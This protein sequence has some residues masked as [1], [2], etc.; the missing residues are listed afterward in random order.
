MLHRREQLA[1]RIENLCD[2]RN[3]PVEAPTVDMYRKGIHLG[4][5]GIHRHK[6]SLRVELEFGTVEPEVLCCVGDMGRKK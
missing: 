5:T 4:P 1:E 6:D 2:R 3:L